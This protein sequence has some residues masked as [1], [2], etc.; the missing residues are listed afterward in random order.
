MSVQLSDSPGVGGVAGV[1]E[2]GSQ[3]LAADMLELCTTTTDY[4]LV[5][6]DLM[7]AHH[8]GAIVLSQEAAT[9]A[10]HRE[11]AELASSIAAT[12]Q[13]EVDQLLT[14]RELWYPDAPIEQHDR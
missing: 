6:I 3:H 10:L 2:M 4:G 12:Q 9:R 1:D 8:S 7:L 11:T 5:F 13:L 14:W